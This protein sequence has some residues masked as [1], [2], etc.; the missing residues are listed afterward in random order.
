MRFA[1]QQLEARACEIVDHLGRN[2]DVGDHDAARLR[3]ARRQHE[4]KL[5]RGKRHRHGGADAFADRFGVIGR[6]AARQIDG[7]HRNARG[8]DV[9]GNRFHHAGERR[10]EAGTEDRVDDQVALGD[11]GEVE[12]P[13]LLVGNLDDRQSEAAENLEVQPRVALDGRH[14]SR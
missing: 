12:I 6:Q 9:C 7:D 4:R 1:R 11:F 3:L 10:L 5:R 13:G 8:V 14:R 2:A